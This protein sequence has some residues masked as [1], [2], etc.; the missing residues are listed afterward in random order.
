VPVDFDRTGTGSSVQCVR[1]FGSCAIV[2]AR[3]RP[4]EFAFANAFKREY[5]VAPGR[6]RR[7]VSQPVTAAQPVTTATTVLP[8]ANE[9]A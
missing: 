4:S 6:Y 5:G 1:V 7:Q 2:S 3:R 8:G 9:P